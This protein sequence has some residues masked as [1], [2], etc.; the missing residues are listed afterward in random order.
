MEIIGEV[1]YRLH[2]PTKARIDD[3]FHVAL[4]KISKERH[5]QRQFPYRQFSMVVSS[6]LWTRYTMLGLTGV[7][8][9]CWFP[10]KDALQRTQ[11]G[12]RW[13][14]SR[15]LIPIY[16]SGMREM[17]WIHLWEKYTYDDQRKVFVRIERINVCVS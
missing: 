11:L 3:I 6:Q 15:W 12:R 13:K 14:V 8:G 10:G 2:L 5:H 17:L 9:K 4:L 7:H 16:S 1:V